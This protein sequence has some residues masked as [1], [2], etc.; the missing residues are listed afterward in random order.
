[1]AKEA[2]KYKNHL[3]LFVLTF[4]AHR[5]AIFICYPEAEIQ[6]TVTTLIMGGRLLLPILR[7]C[8]RL[9]PLFCKKYFF[10]SSIWCP[11]CEKIAKNWHIRCARWA[12]NYNLGNQ[13]WKPIVTTNPDNQ[14]WQQRY[15]QDTPRICQRFAKNMP[16]IC[17]VDSNV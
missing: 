6:H 13:S 5:Y 9:L 16:K 15:V 14:S 1:M 2:V 10:F 7:L 8:L 4:P 11:G 3:V 12:N 17:Q